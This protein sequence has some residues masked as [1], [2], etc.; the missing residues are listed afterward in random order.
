MKPLDDS[1]LHTL[2]TKAVGTEGY[3]KAEW[4]ALE[5]KLVRALAEVE[6]LRDENARLRAAAGRGGR[7]VVA[8]RIRE[9]R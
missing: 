4:K 9:E 2:W 8:P 7:P 5:R 3:N 6:R 1:P